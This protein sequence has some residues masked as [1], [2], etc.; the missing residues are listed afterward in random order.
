MKKWIDI[1]DYSVLMNG[2]IQEALE[3]IDNNKEDGND[4]DDEEEEDEDN[5]D[6]ADVP[7]TIKLQLLKPLSL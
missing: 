7:I 5:T 4:D 6:D 3:A 2:Y 1:E